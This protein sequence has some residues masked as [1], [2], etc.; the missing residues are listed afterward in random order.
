LY[1][2]IPLFILVIL[3]FILIFSEIYYIQINADYPIFL[4]YFE[5]IVVAIIIIYILFSSYEKYWKINELNLVK[6]F[7]F[8]KRLMY[9]GL[10][11]LIIIMFVFINTNNPATPNWSF[12]LFSGLIIIVSGTL[13]KIIINVVKRDF[14]FY[15]ARGCF[16]FLIKRKDHAEKMRYLVMGINSYNKYLKKNLKLQINNIDNLHSKIISNFIIHNSMFLDSLLKTFQTD[17]K[18]LP[19]RY[20]ISFLNLETEQFLVKESLWEKIKDWG[21]FLVAV[22]PV[23]ISIIQL[24]L[25]INS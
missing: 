18:L 16:S 12:P 15:Y 22:I 2:L 21:A 17:N 6:E 8:L 23:A 10:P 5:I 13:S 20:I 24:L 1:I 9:I 19:L 4:K 14:R 11:L 7:E 3:P 25:N